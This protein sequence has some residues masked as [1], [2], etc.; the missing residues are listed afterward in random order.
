MKSII[1][2][3]RDLPFS[4]KLLAVYIVTLVFI[5]SLVTYEQIVSSVSVL[6]EESISNLNILT[7]QVAMTFSQN[8]DNI[9][10]TMY[11]RLRAF[12]IPQRMRDDSAGSNSSTL[13]TALSQTITESTLYDYVM[14]R[15][16]SG[17]V[18]D[19]GLKSSSLPR[20]YDEIREESSLLLEKHGNPSS[21]G[22]WCRAESGRVYVIR[23]IYD[24]EPLCKVGTAVFHMRSDFFR[25]S[26]EYGDI[27]FRFYDSSG[28]YLTSAGMAWSDSSPY[29]F[30]ESTSG[31]WK[32]VGFMSTEQYR[33]MR[34]RIIT[35]SVVYGCV[36]LLAGVV[37]VLM[38][39]RSV[40]G[41]LKTLKVSMEKVADGDLNTRVPVRDNDDISQ[42]SE[43]F[44]YMT[45]RVAGLLEELLEK[46]RLKNDADI[47][48]LEYK[49][50]SLETQI[51]PHFIF[52]AL[53]VINSMAK[54]KGDD[55]IVE[56]VK[57]MSRYFR[58]ITVNTTKQFITVQ[59]E[60]DALE[61][62]TEIHRL[63]HGGRLKT[64]FRA[65]E[66]ACNA[67]VPTMIIQPVVENSL[68]YG[69]RSQEEDSELIVHAYVREDRLHITIKDNG[70]GLT[71]EQLERLKEGKLI[72]STSRSGIGLGNV[73]DR[74]TLLYGIAADFSMTN[75]DDGGVRVEIV[76]PLSYSDPDPEYG[77]D[78][79]DDD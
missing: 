24:T 50:R 34:G 33:S 64:T 45:E 27:G 65:R 44:N 42:M 18:M 39:L 32:T 49:Y 40:T 76:I 2:K 47:Q 20:A 46:E 55:E 10:K 51:R 57:R 67:L 48:V 12:E 29:F 38:L 60:F 56:I 17:A 16:Q 78:D 43:T 79:W 70:Y 52:N 1:K 11:S 54:I 63:I 37:L 4:I 26:D 58:N 62:Y 68:K 7:G 8:Q 75:R 61:D 13:K 77:D 15:L 74:L 21:A 6:E 31:N 69:L 19:A 14:L 66:N 73:Q 72:P 71:D 9:I 22:I 35:V 3:V 23:D 28:A 59:Q 5:V 53:E 25:V 41:K 36:G 30:S